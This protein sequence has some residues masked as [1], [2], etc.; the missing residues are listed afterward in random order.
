MAQGVNGIHGNEIEV[1]ANGTH[2]NE[3]IPLD[4]DVI[5]VG[6][7]LSGVYSL[8][9]T[10]DLG[11]RAKVLEAG[12]G[13]G[14]TWYW[15]RY[16]GCR[17]DSES[18]TYAFSF[19]EK[20]LAEWNW[21]EHFAPQPETEK[22]INFMADKFNLRPHIQLSTRVT[23]ARFDES[24][25]AWEVKTES[26]ETFHSRFLITCL[27]PL[28][29][30]TLP[31]FPGI[32]DFKGTWCHTARWPKTGIDYAGKQVAVIGTG[33]SGVQ[34][35]QEISKTA[36]HL[37]VF[38]RRPNWCSPLHNSK[39]SGKEM[40]EIRKGYPGLFESCRGTYGGFIH[41]ASPKAA[42]ETSPEERERF[43]QAL[44]DSP[45]FG[46]WMGNYR[47]VLVDRDANALLS[48]FVAK[49]I[50]ERVHNQ[51]VAEKLI[52]KDHGFG[53]RRV[54]LETNYYEVYNQD[55]VELVDLNE[56]P[57]ERVTSRGIQT[58][59]GKEREFDVIVYATGFDPVMGAFDRIDIRGLGGRRLKET[60]KVEPETYL[61]M[62]VNGFPNMLMV[63]GPQS[64]FGN[65]PPT[66]QSGVDWIAD[67]LEFVRDNGL[68]Y[69]EP[70]PESVERW[71]AICHESA[72]GLLA[73]EI[74]SWMTGVNINVDGRKKRTVS[75]YCGSC[76]SFREHCAGEAKAGYRGFKLAVQDKLAG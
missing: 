62:T 53:T 1:H 4:Y 43:W 40:E 20:L 47:D 3:T 31:N 29:A 49:K 9:K 57:V 13:V 8:I 12:T 48:E 41:Q 34:A 39:I 19:S 2:V 14:G 11:L 70:K 24:K 6:A 33:A 45:G 32:K 17:F 15:N 56:T 5:I 27:G 72:K 60:W 51:D 68:T 30:F 52:P 44:Y 67:F 64:V 21:T 66:V 76:P 59:D 35:I 54:P 42:L 16:P 74:D 73:S 50:R 10:L 28:T 18:Y 25:S 65:V 22:Y 58:S 36:G 46:I 71:R 23:G 63:M 69:F 55:N 26:N 38:Q 75:R 37:S 7:G 61:G